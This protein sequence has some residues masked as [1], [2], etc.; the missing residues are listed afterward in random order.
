MTQKDE[1]MMIQAQ[2]LLRGQSFGVL[3]SHSARLAG[4]PHSSVL[5]YII[6]TQGCI[7]V[8]ISRLAQHTA[9]IKQNPKVSLFVMADTSGDVQNTARL[10]LS[11]DALALSSQRVDSAAE[12]YY[13]R[14]PQSAGY[15]V[16]L[17]F[18]FY[19]LH[20]KE[21]G[22]IK[23]FGGVCYFDS[24]LWLKNLKLEGAM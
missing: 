17:D 8:L 13:R 10:S 3:S 20:I 9:N 21:V 1:T 18:D 11:C 16:E 2:D 23:G 4:Y 15:H 19:E 5:P 22:F 6:D 7:V 14:F 24:T 12:R